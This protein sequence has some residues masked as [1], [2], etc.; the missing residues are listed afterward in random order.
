MKNSCKLD[1][2]FLRINVSGAVYSLKEFSNS[3]QFTLFKKHATDRAD[4]QFLLSYTH[5]TRKSVD[6][7][8]LT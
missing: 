1:I 4:Y 7:S 2:F 6:K 8:K 3:I 5:E